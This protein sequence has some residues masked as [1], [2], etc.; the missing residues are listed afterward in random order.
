MKREKDCR[1]ERNVSVP[2]QHKYDEESQN[3]IC[4][5]KQDVVQM[6]NGRPQAGETVFRGVGE[7][8]QRVVKPEIRLCENIFKVRS[9][10]GPYVR[11]VGN[12]NVVI[13]VHESVLQT[14]KKGQ[15]GCQNQK[16]GQDQG[17][18]FYQQ[19]ILRLSM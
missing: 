8:Y 15:E 7:L 1:N 13:A 16:R 11:V 10:K 18:V 14:R 2:A 3:R 5:V 9:R 19:M 4:A 17:L 12:K 6:V